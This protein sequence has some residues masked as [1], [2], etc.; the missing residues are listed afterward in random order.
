MYT[1]PLHIEYFPHVNGGM[2]IIAIPEEDRYGRKDASRI[3]G[4]VDV[5]GDKIFYAPTGP[6]WLNVHPEV[7]AALSEAVAE[8]TDEDLNV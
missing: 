6:L 2:R 4:A 7:R 5:V 3:L 8:V 1:I